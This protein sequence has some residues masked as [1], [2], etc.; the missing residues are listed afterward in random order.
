MLFNIS[1]LVQF[2]SLIDK[3]NFYIRFFF[4][5]ISYKYLFS[6]R[7]KYWNTNEY[8]NHIYFTM[9]FLII[10]YNMWLKFIIKKKKER[11]KGEKNIIF[12]KYNTLFICTFINTQVSLPSD[13]CQKFRWKLTFTLSSNEISFSRPCLH[14]FQIIHHF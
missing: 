2:F 7:L 10:M 8:W 14:Y 9:S 6:M 11:E 4:S 5:K 12:E 3:S 1:S 13:S